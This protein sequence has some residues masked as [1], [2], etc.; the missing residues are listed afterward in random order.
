MSLDKP[1]PSLWP[2]DSLPWIEKVV[3]EAL[4]KART[5]EESLPELGPASDGVIRQLEAL[6]GRLHDFAAFA[7][8]SKPAI[9][10]IDEQ[11]REGEDEMREFL[12]TVEYLRDK[13]AEQPERIK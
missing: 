8:A 3:A 10:Q 2:K 6:T 7:N 12:G 4:A 9:A 11:F 5:R 13:L 1:D